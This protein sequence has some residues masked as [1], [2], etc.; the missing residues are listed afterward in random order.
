MNEQREIMYAERRRVLD[1]ESMRNSIM[2]MITDYVENVVN[3][4]VSEDKDANDGI[5]MRL[6]SFFFQLF[7]LREWNTERILRIRMN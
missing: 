4:C 1:G 6:M 7:L 2:K 5:M 3:R